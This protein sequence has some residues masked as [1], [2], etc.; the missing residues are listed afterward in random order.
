MDRALSRIIDETGVDRAAIRARFVPIVTEGD[1]FARVELDLP[2]PQGT[3]FA[4]MNAGITRAADQ[5]GAS[6]LD[7]IELGTRPGSSRGLE[8]MLGVGERATHRLTLTPEPDGGGEGEAAPRPKHPRVGVVFDDLG[9]SMDGLVRS[10]Y[11]CESP[12][13]F[14]VIAGLEHSVAFAESARAHGHEVIVHVPMEPLDRAEHD[15]GKNAILADLDPIENMRRLR[16][17]LDGLTAYTG[18]SNHMGSRV[19]A[20]PALMA[21]VMEEMRMRSRTSGRELFFLDSRTTPLSVVPREARRAGVRVLVNN[22][23]LDG[24]RGANVDSRAQAVR[25]EEIAWRRGTAIAIGH[26]GGDTVEAVLEAA[27]RW[28]SVGIE[29]VT[30]SQLAGVPADRPPPRRP[31]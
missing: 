3:S 20:D 14:G 8:I 1:S 26:V 23:F 19:T 18:V 27:K 15:P 22:L 17:H 11:R 13:T 24:P 16:L 5:A 9:Y 28:K 30:L 12:L 2:V 29:M 4:R 25:L 21:L 7:V 6:I 10:L 31:S